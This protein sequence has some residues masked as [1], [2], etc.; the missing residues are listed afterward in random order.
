MGFVKDKRLGGFAQQPLFP[1]APDLSSPE[2]LL[3]LARLQGGAVGEVAEELVNPEKSFLSRVG[4]TLGGGFQKFVNTML[5][6]S[7]VV[8]GVLSA[9]HTVREALD[10]KLMPSDVLFGEDSLDP[11]ATAMEKVGN[12][13][14]RFTVDVLLDPLTYVTFGASRGIIGL[15]A[16][17]KVPVGAPGAKKLLA[18]SDKG[19][20]LYQKRVQMQ[21][22]GITSSATKTGTVRGLEG[23]S[24]KRFVKETLDSELDRE[25]VK[26]SIGNL[27]KHKP[28]YVET[29]LDKGGIK[30]FGNT[31]L[32]G[33][34]INAVAKVI[35]GTS[36]VD[37]ATR[38]MRNV[39]GAMFNRDFDATFGRLPDEFIQIEQ[40]A[41]DLTQARKIKSL[42][43]LVDVVKAFKLSN[44]EAQLLMSS[45]EHNVLP[46]DSRLFQ[47]ALRLKG[48]DKQ[49]LKLLRAN[50]SKVHEMVNHLPHVLVDE[51]ISNIPFRLPPKTSTFFA[52]KSRQVEGA[53]EEI[54][55]KIGLDM[56]DPNAITALAKRGVRID[57]AATMREFVRDVARWGGV[58]ASKAPRGYRPA[59]VK[60]LENE[61]IE[62]SQF[63]TAQTGE[64]LYFHPAVAKRIE[65]FS[66]SLINDEATNIVLR[67]FDDVQGIFKASVTSIF[68]AFHG[69]N[70]I[71][72]VFLEFMD[73][74][75]H[76]LNP[77]NQAIAGDLVYKDR[78]ANR[79]A[80]EAM[81]IT[82][83]VKPGQANLLDE[84]PKFGSAIEQNFIPTTQPG[85]R[86][87]SEFGAKH[88][89]PENARIESEAFDHIATTGE[90]NILAQAEAQFGKVV[91]TDDIR[92][93]FPSYTGFNSAGVHEPSSYLAGK[94]FVKKLIENKGRGNNTIFF[95]AGGTGVGKTS[96]VKNIPKLAAILDD[97]P[98]MYDN[99][100]AIVES[101][102][103][104]IEAALAE[105]YRVHVEYVLREP[106]ESLVSG[107]L[108]RATK[109]SRIVPIDAHLAAHVNSRETILKLVKKYNDNPNVFI[110]VIDN[111]KNLK[112]AKVGTLKQVKNSR[113]N[114]NQAEVLRLQLY[115]ELE[116][117]FKQRKISPEVYA[118]SKGE[119]GFAD[120]F[121]GELGQ[122][123]A[124]SLRES[125]AR[126][127]LVP[128][129]A[130]ERLSEM[131]SR[132]MFTDAA[133]YTWSFGEIR[134]LL[135][136]TQV[137]FSPRVTGALDVRQTQKE[138]I[139]ALFPENFGGSIAK[140][141]LPISQEF[142]PFKVG[143]EFGRM[144]E[145]QAR[146][147]SFLVNLKK[148][149]D[150]TLAATR[151]KQFLFDY[152]NL[153]NFERVFLRRLIP[154][155]TFTRKNV[156]LQV[157]SLMRTPGRAVTQV[158]AFTTL[159]DIIA[160][161]KLSKEE[162][163]NLPDWV[164]NGSALLLSKRGS[165]VELLQSLGTPLEQPFQAFDVGGFLG[166]IS[167]LVRLPLETATGYSW[168]QQ[169]PV[170]DITNAAAF[171]SA[172]KV[173]KDYI[174]FT[175][176]TGKKDNG[177]EFNWFVSLRP[178]RMHV[179]L[180]LPPTSRVLSSLKQMQTADVS[181]QFRIAQQLV[182]IRPFT[183]D[184]EQQANLRERELKRRLED[185]LTSARV[186]AKFQ[187]TFIPKDSTNF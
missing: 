59:K 170:Q 92:S 128:N 18:L 123:D 161:E 100:L 179:L 160:G 153:S 13:F 47:A 58:A 80:R 167:P 68:V 85:K 11:D 39:L 180:N 169:K 109:T 50:G 138:L 82:D 53:V 97:S 20:E 178:E 115:E 26:T 9:D 168:F 45:I 8:A 95:T 23:E 5:I 96:G 117:Q 25:F 119:F 122:G 144:V 3:E 44:K 186:T 162:Q 84:A 159:G 152:D 12:F 155:Y 7:N 121:K 172:P 16:R 148:T 61:L 81:G 49:Q 77:G 91:N 182:G 108:P 35:P 145:E 21:I 51:K 56:F 69:R 57:T 114:K 63:V 131:L 74:G 111:T 14:T 54:N 43:D 83:V 46:A 124:R 104:K 116:K 149:G 142:L 22:A 110:G 67:K 106:V 133:G 181:Q 136:S 125:L 143:R 157:N 154:F 127:G 78:I 4:N 126:R 86:L 10:Q 41:R 90:E 141:A 135:K 62:F 147:T 151:A 65:E 94:L 42:A 175:E 173:I 28:H 52:E 118:G 60:G 101:S 73:I 93:L 32:S 112:N 89:S 165:T 79:L 48:I 36:F 166:S 24:L 72:N 163:D 129:E 150:P 140:K 31:I 176:V 64:E 187:R 174:G 103:R 87:S 185:L 55:E 1:R 33:Q 171:K 164:K 105:G 88:L 107:T 19:E 137:A 113:Y 71:S 183:F 70:A 75:V 34:R 177:E 6:P 76:A 66:G 17:V 130:S 120:D 102:V 158:K 98:I 139:Q 184:L 29:L 40:K 30:F 99:N 27:L 15:G 132:E 37:H 146:I 38:P 156:A 2:G 134:S